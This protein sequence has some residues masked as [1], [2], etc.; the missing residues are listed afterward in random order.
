MKNIIIKDNIISITGTTDDDYISLTDIAK[1]KNQKEPKDVV[2]NWLRLS[3]TLEFI[4]LWEQ[5]N[6]PHFNRV[7]FDPLLFECRR[8]SSFLF[9]YCFYLNKIFIILS[10]GE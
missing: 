7:E 3:S 8:K 2:K 6:N 9:F 10:K 4:G 5:F 1:I